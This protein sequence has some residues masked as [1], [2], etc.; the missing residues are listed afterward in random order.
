MTA[1]PQLS[2]ITPVEERAGFLVKRD[3]LFEYGGSAGGKVRSC[4]ALATAS[5]PAPRGLVT[6]AHRHSPQSAIVA[7]VAHALGIPCRVH[8]PASGEE[9]TAELEAALALGAEL[10]PVR[11]GYNSVITKAAREDAAKRGWLEIPFG[12]ECLHAVE[13][14]ARQAAA[15][16]REGYRRIVVPVG[17]GMSLAGI[18][19]GLRRAGNWTPVLGV[20]VGADRRYKLDQWAPPDWRTRAMLVASGVPYNRAVHAELDGLLLDPIYEAKCARFLQ[21]GDLLWVV[22]IRS[23]AT[24]PGRTLTISAATLDRALDCTLH[25]ITRPGGCGGRCCTSP[26]FWPP[27]AQPQEDGRSCHYLGP[28][29]CTLSADDKPVVCLLYPFMPPAPGSTVLRMHFR[30]P[31]LYCKPNYQR[32][33]RL[34]EAMRPSLVALV[35]EEQAAKALEDDAAGRSITLHLPEAVAKAL[36]AEE[37]EHEAKILPPPRST[38]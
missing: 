9:A 26:A 4:L 34:A 19:T 16:P 35:G 29:G 10:C 22:G 28:E 13:E 5:D 17:S 27:N 11:P 14:N 20:M 32:G 18:L 36:E 21:P 3:D 31:T 6:S 7:G 25:G 37:A 24:A 8:Y 12:M 2:A 23:T 33:P 1:D 15:L 30:A 38:R